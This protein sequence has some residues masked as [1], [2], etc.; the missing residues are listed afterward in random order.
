MSWVAPVAVE[1][2]AHY[3]PEAS[4]H[5]LPEVTLECRDL[6]KAFGGVRAVD[7]VN[8]SF[9]AGKVTAL[10][11]PNGAGKTTLFHLMSGALAPDEGEVLFQGRRID[12]Q[13]PWAVAQMGVGRLFQDVRVFPKLTAA[14]NLLV[15]GR[16]VPGE[17]VLGALFTRRKEEERRRAAGARR[18]LEAVGLLEYEHEPAEALSYGQQKL[19]AM[20]RLLAAAAEVLLLDEPT[21]GVNPQLIDRLLEVIR[22]LAAEGRTVVLIEH[23]MTVVL[24]VADWVYFMDDGEVVMFGLAEEVLSDET[25]KRSYL[26]L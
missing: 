11:G 18:W 9:E 22:G 23:N 8:A 14:E 7:G 20:A 5:A 1:P 15:A 13:P 3:R 25:L 10:V 21:A 24:E 4:V 26:G 12:G 19:L 16:E 17:G 2:V 6:S